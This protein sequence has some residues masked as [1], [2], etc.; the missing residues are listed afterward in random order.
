[1]KIVLNKKER[2]ISSLI[3]SLETEYEINIQEY[4]LLD[5]RAE[6]REEIRKVI[7]V[8]GMSIIEDRIIHRDDTVIWKLNIK[9]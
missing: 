4:C 3:Y 1:M 5:E 7:K 9:R 6:F 2:L 8:V